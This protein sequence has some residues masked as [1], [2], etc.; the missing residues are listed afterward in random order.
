MQSNKTAE[1]GNIFCPKLFT[2]ML[3]A[4]YLEHREKKMAPK[5]SP[6]SLELPNSFEKMQIKSWTSNGD[7]ALT[8]DRV[9]FWL[10]SGSEELYFAATMFYLEAPINILADFSSAYDWIFFFAWLFL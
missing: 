3:V 7:N 5:S 9:Q 1:N 2:Y 10:S 6:Q 8:S 4:E